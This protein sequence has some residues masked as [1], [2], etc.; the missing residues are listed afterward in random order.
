MKK[1]FDTAGKPNKHLAMY[2]ELAKKFILKK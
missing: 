2:D 1:V